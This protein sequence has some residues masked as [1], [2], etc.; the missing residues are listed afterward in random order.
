MNLAR[1]P[2]G[3]WIVGQAAHADL[4]DVLD[5][6]QFGDAIDPRSVIQVPRRAVPGVQVSIEVDHGYRNVIGAQ[7]G[8]RDA[9]VSAEHDGE[10]LFGED[11]ADGAGDLVACLRRNRG[12]DLDVA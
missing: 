4:D 7:H 10:G 11:R 8:E 6:A 9:V 3:L 5:C 2:H 12:E 1:I